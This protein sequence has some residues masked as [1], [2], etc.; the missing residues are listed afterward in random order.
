MFNYSLYVVKFCIYKGKINYNNTSF[1]Y[2]QI[3]YLMPLAELYFNYYE[4][5]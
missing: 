3:K 4:R 2:F 1:N 5:K